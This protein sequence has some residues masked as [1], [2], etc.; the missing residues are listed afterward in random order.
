MNHIPLKDFIENK[1]KQ[2]FK[3]SFL[4]VIDESY[5][6]AGHNPNAKQ[7]NTHFKIIIASQQL[8]GLRYVEQHK[9]IYAALAPWMNAPIHALS[10]QILSSQ[11]SS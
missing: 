5:K 6:H 10:I 2:D 8:A 11:T 4:E 1:L 7:G 9:H 3:P